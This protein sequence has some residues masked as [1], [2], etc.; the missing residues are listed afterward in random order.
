MVPYT[1]V[2]FSCSSLSTDGSGD[3]L[4]LNLLNGI[5]LPYTGPD[6]PDVSLDYHPD[7]Y[8]QFQ[9]DFQTQPG[10]YSHSELTC[11]VRGTTGYLDGNYGGCTC[12]VSNPD[13]E[14]RIIDGTEAAVNEFPW[15]V[16][17][18]QPGT[19]RAL[20]AGT[21][22]AQKWILTAAHCVEQGSQLADGN[23]Q[24]QVGEHLTLS[25]TEDHEEVTV[26]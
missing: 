12:G 6:L 15:Q 16:A 11:T 10:D 23:V 8:Y 1:N 3:T 18:V 14:N 19:H 13:T 9:V 4:T 5:V 26:L 22:V 20:C 2:H 24:V 21:I 17:L 7:Y 25:N